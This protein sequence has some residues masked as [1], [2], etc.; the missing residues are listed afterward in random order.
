MKTLSEWATLTSGSPQ[1]RI[2]ETRAAS[3]P[4][5][6]Y[7]SQSDFESDRAGL[8][9]AA[10]AERRQVRTNDA[11]STLA[12]GDVVFSLLTGQAARVGVSHAGFLY[13]QNYVRLA[14][15][16]QLDAGF[17]VYL[18]NEDRAIRHQL[19]LGLQGSQVLKYTLRQ[20]KELEPGPLPPLAR[21]KA[22]GDV[23]A[24]QLCLKALRERTAR[25]EL[26]IQLEKLRE[27]AN[28]E[29]STI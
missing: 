13:T 17:L 9:A 22:I 14:P 1:F 15:V 23:Y 18:L 8:T 11:V 21:Q 12:T 25:L 26:T 27:A 16:R 29:R 7:Y 2:R 6:T 28:H 20:L 24:R 19:H 4:L 5:Y 10:D 3:A